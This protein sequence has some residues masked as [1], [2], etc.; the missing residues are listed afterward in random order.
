M[1]GSFP[2]ATPARC[3]SQTV[4]ELT[5]LQQTAGPSTTQASM[6]EESLI[7]IHH[8][9][10][11]H[12]VTSGEQDHAQVNQPVHYHQNTSNITEM[13]M[14]GGEILTPHYVIVEDP[15]ALHSYAGLSSDGILTEYDLPTDKTQSVVVVEKEPSS[16]NYQIYTAD[17]VDNDNRSPSAE[18]GP[19][20]T[21]IRSLK[22]ETILAVPVIEVH[23]PTPE[24]RY[25]VSQ[26][27]ETQE[28]L[29]K[30]VTKKAAEKI[31]KLKSNNSKEHSDI[32]E[33]TTDMETNS[34]D[35]SVIFNKDYMTKLKPRLGSYCAVSTEAS[36]NTMETM[37]SS[38]TSD[39]SS[40]IKQQTQD[41]IAQEKTMFSE[42][43]GLI[44]A[45]KEMKIIAERAKNAAK[46]VRTRKSL[47]L[48]VLTSSVERVSV[49]GAVRDSKV[50]ADL[51]P[52]ENSLQQGHK[53]RPGCYR[54]GSCS[55]SFLTICKLHDHLQD[56]CFGG[57]YHFDHL[58][59]TAFPKYDTTCS[60]AQTDIIFD[61]DLQ[62]TFIKPQKANVSIKFKAPRVKPRRLLAKGSI[63]KSVKK[64]RGRPRKID[65]V[66]EETVMD[67]Q[68]E[69]NIMD[70][71]AETPEEIILKEEPI[72]FNIDGTI[73]DSNVENSKLVQ[74]VEP[75]VEFSANTTS[76]L[77]DKYLKDLE[78]DIAMI[79]KSEPEKEKKKMC[80]RKMSIPRKI[81]V[82][83]E[84][85]KIVN[86]RTKPEMKINCEFCSSKFQ[87]TRGLIRHEQEKHADQMKHDCDQCD[88]KFMREYNLER[89]KLCSHNDD[90][91]S[92]SKSML[93]RRGIYREKRRAGRRPRD[94][95]PELITV[96]EICRSDVPQAKLDI[97]IRLHTGRN[98]YTLH[99]YVRMQFGEILSVN[100]LPPSYCELRAKYI[101]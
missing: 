39:E 89:H 76:E 95:S 66:P 70:D 19:K 65:V 6:G 41:K 90:T 99:S 24:N 36:T 10:D 72:S 91:D 67:I 29:R 98:T 47:E 61:Q 54:C 44:P 28:H 94:K 88:Q 97:H 87:Y 93:E 4:E 34:S 60:Y 45:E 48:R 18:V 3:I 7:G 51:H 56:H 35:L 96:C 16:N 20:I 27:S 52:D 31:E 68:T 2:T 55:R 11:R 79:S 5:H 40:G 77:V 26:L 37:T 42:N 81:M 58:L 63:P 30:H 64:K 15:I 12:I 59:K 82:T 86:S 85:E 74:E 8:L 92:K 49:Q 21:D 32:Y 62:K 75:E 80:K 101:S 78:G 84:S 33:S 13:H 73:F 22:K 38:D 25:S 17:A 14:A 43:L 23:K 9:N 53:H 100:C 50:N 71:Q 57:S 46:G 1:E 83:S 69:M